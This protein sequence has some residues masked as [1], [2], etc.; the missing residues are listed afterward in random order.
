MNS[1]RD[2][3]GKAWSCGRSVI[4]FAKA[5]AE[6]GFTPEVSWIY[7][8]FRSC[9]IDPRK[10]YGMALEAVARESGSRLS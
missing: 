8:G 4:W 5:A 7:W 9:G 2:T 10:A 3:A 1:Q 6:R